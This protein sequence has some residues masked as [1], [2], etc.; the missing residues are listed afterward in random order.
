[1]RA[2]FTYDIE[3]DLATFDEIVRN[4]LEAGKIDKATAE[5]QWKASS[6]VELALPIGAY[7]RWNWTPEAKENLRKIRAFL[8]A[9]RRAA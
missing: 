5:R 8:A 2:N 3:R 7:D 4:A 9:R 6:T 1:M